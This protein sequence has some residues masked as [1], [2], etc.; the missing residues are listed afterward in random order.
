MQPIN[1]KRRRTVDQEV[2]LSRTMHVKS[3]RLLSHRHFSPRNASPGRQ[4]LSSVNNA[5]VTSVL[6]ATHFPANTTRRV[7]KQLAFLQ[8]YEKLK[9]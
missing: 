6:D 8:P 2:H 9:H 7:T 1:R 3:I 5:G 4:L